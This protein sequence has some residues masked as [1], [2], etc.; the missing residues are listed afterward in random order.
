MKFKKYATLMLGALVFASC[1]DIDEQFPEGGNYTDEQ[2]QEL[3]KAVPSR[4]DAIFSG[5]FSMMAEPHLAL[6][7]TRADDFG[8]VMAALSLDAEGSDLTLQDNGYN[9]FSACGKLTSR[10]ANYANPYIRYVIPY[11]QIGVANQVIA[12]YA[13]DNDEEKWRIAQA[14]AIIAFDYLA[15]APYFQYRYV[16]AADKPC[17]PIIKEGADYG[18]N[19]RATVK[20]VYEFILKNLDEAIADLEGYQ[21]PDKSKIDINVAYGLRARAYLNMGMYAEAAADAEKALAGYTPATMKEMSTPAFCNINESNWIWGIAVTD[22]QVNA[23][24]YPT[25]SSWISAFSGDGYAAATVNVPSINSLLYKKIPDSDVRKGWWLNENLQSPLLEGLTWTDGKTGQSASGQDI[26]A[27]AIEDVK[28]PFIAYN[29]VKFGMKS[30]VGSTLN[31]NDFPLMRVEEMILIQAEGLAKSGNADK[32]RQ[33]LENFVRTYR[34]PSY[35]STGRNLSLEDEIWFQRRVELWG[36]GFATSDLQRLK[37]PIVRFHGQASGKED[38]GNFPAA[39]RFNVPA[40]DPWRL[41]RFP[42]T[43]ID[44]NSEITTA[45]NAGGS[46]PEPDSHGE[47][48]DGVT[49]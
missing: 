29:S 41:L 6:G 32:A 31:N 2:V 7:G 9:W 44:N 4:A 35:I 27:F 48:L 47:L 18:S 22:G 40:D 10:N 28:E 46:V 14:K 15:L 34:D 42:Q 21:R 38:L 39:F 26:P 8:F 13:G 33:I 43:E 49:D 37:K 23:D 3:N 11:N 1:N 36:E 25:S 17:V 16:D 5:M 24:G 30:G 12:A 20:E 45:D 19:P